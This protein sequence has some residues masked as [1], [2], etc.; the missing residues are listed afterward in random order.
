M[1]NTILGLIIL[2][3]TIHFTII[4]HGKS[5]AD[6]TPYQKAVTIAGMIS[7]GLIYLGIIMGV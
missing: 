1:L 7:I 3:T 5:F 6:R 2:Y 4:Q